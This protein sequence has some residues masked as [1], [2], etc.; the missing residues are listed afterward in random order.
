MAGRWHLGQKLIVVAMILPLSACATLFGDRNKSIK[1]SSEPAGAEIF[2]DDVP[3]G[4]TPKTIVL[5]NINRDNNLSLRLNGYD[6]YA[7]PLPISFQY[8]VLLNAFF[9]P[10]ALVD[11]ATDSFF[12][13]EQSELHVTLE[14]PSSV[15]QD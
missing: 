7:L 4:R 13:L 6:D 10:G 3:Q 1:I 2:I 8:I 11:L 15:V 9:W 12:R 5:A 14:K